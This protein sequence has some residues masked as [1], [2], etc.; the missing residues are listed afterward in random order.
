MENEDQRPDDAALDAA[1]RRISRRARA[2]DSQLPEPAFEQGGD[3]DALVMQRDGVV[4]ALAAVSRTSIA[5]DH[6]DALWGACTR[7]EM[8]IAWDGEAEAASELLSRWIAESLDARED[9]GDWETSLEVQVA[10]RDSDLVLPLLQRGF[11]QVG[12]T[13]IR[14]GGRRADERSVLAHLSRAGI[15]L[16]RATPADARLLGEMDAELL[17]HDALHGAVE[18]RAGAAGV[19]QRG[20]EERLALDPE[21]TWVIEG[22]GGPAGYLSLE[23][24]RAQHRAKCAAGGPLAYIQAMYL[25]PTVRGG[26]IGEAVVGFAHAR[27]ALAGYDRI[28]LG[29]AALNPRS[30]PFWCRMGYRPLWT[31]WQRR[32]ARPAA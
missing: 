30:G 23:I 20:I 14:V 24:D 19:L 12:V 13:A 9:A 1:L 26:G 29:Y 8:R 18:L 10:S 3:H 4:H 16:R 32:P 25:R 7:S 17:A 11:A 27:A 2:M 6:P 21:W 31:S 22:T 5:P 28:L 15:E